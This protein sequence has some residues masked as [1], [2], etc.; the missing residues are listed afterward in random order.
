MKHPKSAAPIKKIIRACGIPRSDNPIKLAKQLDI[1][2]TRIPKLPKRVPNTCNVHFKTLIV[3]PGF[4][5]IHKEWRNVP[6][7]DKEAFPARCICID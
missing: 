1:I 2:S 5:Q 6:E 7:A 4:G 3:K